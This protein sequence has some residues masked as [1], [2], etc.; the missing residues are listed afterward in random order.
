[1]RIPRSPPVLAP[2][3]PSL[4]QSQDCLNEPHHRPMMMTR[5]LRPPQ[6]RPPSPP[7]S[8]AP[9]N[10]API[11]RVAPPPPARAPSMPPPPP[12]LPHRTSSS[13]AQ[14]SP[15]ASSMTIRQAPPVPPPPTP[16]MRGQS[17]QRNGL[18]EFEARFSDMFHS[19]STFP[20]PEPF[21]NIP[22]VL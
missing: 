8:R 5:V 7:T 16:P 18:V 3:P 22:K 6:A 12:P 11:T 14:S 19:I 10:G 15:N 21:R 9:S 20:S 4:H 2:T 17:L 1:M 13:A